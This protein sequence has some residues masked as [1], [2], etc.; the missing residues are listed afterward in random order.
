MEGSKHQSVWITRG[1]SETSP[2]VVP[3]LPGLPGLPLL[4]AKKSVEQN[5]RK[6]S[7]RES[8]PATAVNKNAVTSKLTQ[9][10]NSLVITVSVADVLIVKCVLLTGDG[11]LDPQTV[12]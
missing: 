5:S 12:I 2:D 4:G 9:T 3:S 11:I 10:H 1:D 8:T 6:L 7:K